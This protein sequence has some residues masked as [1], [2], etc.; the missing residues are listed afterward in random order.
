MIDA[1]VIGAGQYG[2]AASW[3]L[4]RR[5]IE[6]VVIE[7]GRVA[8]TWRAQRWDAFALNTPNWMN[9]LAG[10][11]EAVGP[12]DAFL[13]RDGWIARLEDHARLSQAPVR[14]ATTV[15]GVDAGPRPGAFVVAV[16]GPDGPDAI[17]TRHVVI[18]SGGQSAPRR[19]TISGTLPPEVLQLHTSDYRS[20]ADLPGGAVLVVGSAQSGVQVAEDLV[21][22]GRATHLA[23]S[24]VAR[25]RR[26]YRGR[27][28]LEWLI[29]CG[30]YDATLEQLPDPRMAKAPIP[31]ISGVGRYGHTVSLQSLADLG[32][33]L[34][35]RP[36]GAAGGRI[37][38]DHSLGANIAAGD[39]GSAWL[40]GI[41]EAWIERTVGTPPP[42]EPDPADTPHPDPTSV[43]GPAVLDLERDRVGAVIW[44]TGYEAD[45]GYLHVPVL[46]ASGFPVH[47]HGAARL[48]GIH[49][50]G[51]RWLNDRKSALI[52]AADA[53]AGAMADR[54]A[55][56]RS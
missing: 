51:L 13:T 49:F 7:R 12:R 8:E 17:E 40:N 47:D 26:R 23:T 45:F 18:A 21:Q 16:E 31:Q 22:A 42:V 48:P 5:G 28:S 53:E 1:V 38:F 52:T 24:P 15:T 11:P 35:G 50:L 32:V 43:R 34:L 54:V 41:M 20:P 44:A 29:E 2:L 10:E 25:L 37:E 55:A 46:D 39:R 30:F 3:H 6:H 36:V 4:S 56:S 33:R 14:T 9:R 19:P 27:D